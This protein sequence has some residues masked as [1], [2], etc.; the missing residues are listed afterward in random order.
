MSLERKQRDMGNKLQHSSDLVKFITP[1]V[2]SQTTQLTN[3]DRAVIVTIATAIDHTIYLPPV[4][5][6]IGEIY[7]FRCPDAGSGCTVKDYGDL[8]SVDWTD[9]A[10]DADGDNAVVISDG[11]KWIVLALDEN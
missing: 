7:T 8:D 1:T 9:I 4:G 11:F 3:S 5:E 10:L 2:T 6:C